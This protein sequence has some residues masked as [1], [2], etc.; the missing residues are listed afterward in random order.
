LKIVAKERIDLANAKI[1]VVSRY[2]SL[3]VFVD[4]KI[5]SFGA[6]RRAALLANL[7]S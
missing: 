5:R 7:K 1:F 2:G 4:L 3:L 6:T